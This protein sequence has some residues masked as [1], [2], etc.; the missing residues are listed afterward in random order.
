LFTGPVVIA[1]TLLVAG[2]VA[3]RDTVIIVFGVVVF[4]YSLMLGFT[5]QSSR[6]EGHW[7]WTVILSL[8]CGGLAFGLLRAADE[9]GARSTRGPTTSTTTQTP[10]P[11]TTISSPRTVAT[12]TPAGSSTTI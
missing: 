6:H 8:F 10:L 5:V 11:S 2:I 9:L 7:V 3:T 12:T 1:L 4:V